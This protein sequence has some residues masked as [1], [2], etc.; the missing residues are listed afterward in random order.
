M[1]DSSSDRNPGLD[2]ARNLAILLVLVQHIVC[3]GGLSNDSMGLAH[4]LQARTIEAFS[5]CCVDL[6][7]LLSGYLGVA[8]LSWNWKK[9]GRL[10]LQVWTTGL[11]VCGVCALG[12]LV[13]PSVFGGRL[14][15]Q[16]DW[17]TAAC[18]LLR[19]EYWYFT[20]YL[21]VF[22]LAPL[23]NRTVFAA[24]RERV[25]I[26]AAGVVFLLVCGT[27]ACPGGVDRL[28]LA[29]GYSAA[30]LVCLYVFGAALRRAEDRLRP[31]RAA[32]FF[33]LTALCVA[34]TAGQRL[35]MASVPALKSLFAGEW[36]LHHYTSPTITLAA[37][38]TLL[39]CARLRPCL[40]VGLPGRLNAALAPCAFGIYL[41]HVQ[42]FFFLSMF[43]GRFVFL[44]RVPDSL[45][46]VSV[47]GTAVGLYFLFAALEAARRRLWR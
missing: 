34:V 12:G 45:F 18:P 32:H 24:G 15:T 6:F 11:L 8:T 10:W 44:D 4:K 28:P 26:A 1:R 35:A 17:L 5:Q 42:P 25:G 40:F 43:K 36:T 13:A 41:L 2:L 20:G 3:L 46:A 29:K 39:G 7:G 19:D 37:A 16:A 22:L 14:P 31:L 27:T 21:F 23:L 33:G 47:V 30:W 9:L 38:A